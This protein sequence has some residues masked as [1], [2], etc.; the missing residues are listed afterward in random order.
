MKKILVKTFMSLGLIV[1]LFVA[2]TAA[3]AEEVSQQNQCECPD[4]VF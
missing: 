2:N 4:F 3:G 1:I